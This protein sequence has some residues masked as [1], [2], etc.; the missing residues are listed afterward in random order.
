MCTVIVCTYIYS[1]NFMW[2]PRS[3]TYCLSC[4]SCTSCLL[5][6][7]FFTYTCCLL[8]SFISSLTDSGHVTPR[9]WIEYYLTYIETWRWNLLLRNFSFA[10]FQCTFTVIKYEYRWSCGTTF[11]S[12]LDIL[13]FLVNLKSILIITNSL[14][15]K[16]G[17]GSM[18]KY[19]YHFIYL[20]CFFFKNHTI[21]GCKS[22]LR[23]L[24]E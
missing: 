5:F 11:F 4:R 13:W 15:I 16:A 12:Y 2:L 10:S 22:V 18:S 3:Y 21:Y 19:N 8:L 23:D 6:F 17:N 20:F 14:A 1:A 24:I 7:P 9:V